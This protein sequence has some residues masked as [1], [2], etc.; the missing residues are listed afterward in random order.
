MGQQGAVCFGE[1][2]LRFGAEPI[3][4]M[5]FTSSRPCAPF[6]HKPVTLQTQQMGADSVI[7]EIQSS[8]ELI[9]GVVLAPQ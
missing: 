5:R 4:C 6:L 1:D 3:C 7:G 8:G 2:M 9:D